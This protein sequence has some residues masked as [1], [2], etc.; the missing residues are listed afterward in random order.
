MTPAKTLPVSELTVVVSDPGLRIPATCP[1]TLMLPRQLLTSGDY[2]CFV[3]A[4]N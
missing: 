1:E 3:Q 2:F 4:F